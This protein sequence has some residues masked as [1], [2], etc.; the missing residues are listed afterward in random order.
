MILKKGSAGAALLGCLCLAGHMGT[1]T[2]SLFT[3]WYR[4]D[5]C[6]NLAHLTLCFISIH[7]LLSICSIFFCHEGASAAYK[8]MNYRWILQR[9]SAILIVLLIHVHTK[10]YSHM[11]TGVPLSG[12]WSL[13]Y[14]LSEVLYIAFVAIHVGLSFSRALLT[15]GWV[16]SGRIIRYIDIGAG[17]VCGAAGICA[18]TAVIR[19]FG[20]A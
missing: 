18:A 12:G 1:M 14:C 13:L 11:A 4:L 2:F 19:F 9:A 17:I 15:F 20:G 16:Q 7:A 8:K 6:K 10:A 3:G 5:L